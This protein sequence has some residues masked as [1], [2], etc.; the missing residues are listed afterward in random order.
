MIRVNLMGL[1]KERKRARA[2]AIDFQG[3]VPLLLLVL[4]V[5]AVAA[6]TY[7]Q[8]NRLE[9]QIAQLQM[10]VADLD[11]EF[12]DLQRIKEEYDANIARREALTARINVITALQARQTGPVDLLSTLAS[13]VVNTDMLWLN[14]FRQTGQNV[15]IEGTALNVRAVADFLTRLLNARVF[16]TVDL[17]ETSQDPQQRDVDQFSFTLN[18]QLAPPPA[19]EA[20]PAA[21]PGAAPST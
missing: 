8:H 21:A 4:I 20:S 15:A 5:G 11:R 3:G 14:S 18:G 16:S 12:Q 1:P 2:P 10:N 13:A 19:P 6:W 9:Q 7:V 17:Q